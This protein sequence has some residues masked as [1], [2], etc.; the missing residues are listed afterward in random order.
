MST[1]GNLPNTPGATSTPE[2]NFTADASAMFEA[3]R[4]VHQPATMV[5]HRGDHESASFFVVPDR[6]KLH[7]VK[8]WLDARRPTPE[9][10]RGTA[11]LATLESFITHAKRS[12]GEAG[13]CAVFVDTTPA[14][15]SMR[16]IY[17]Y[18]Q[19]GAGSAGARWCDHGAL[20]RFPLSRA[21]RAWTSLGGKS[22][23]QAELAAFI[24][25][26]AHEVCPPE[27]EGAATAVL[28]LERVGLT[29]ATPAEVLTASRGLA[30]SVETVVENS[31]VL[32]TGEAAFIF[33]EKVR[34]QNGQ[35]LTVPGGFVIAV[36]VFEGA[37]EVHALPV[38][39]RFRAKDGVVT[40]TL[41]P[42]GADDVVRDAVLQAKERVVAE[43]P[44][45]EV[46]EGSPEA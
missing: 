8:G 42:L 35:K 38:R 30:A 31:T 18:H 7:D 1:Q 23:T 10:A 36:P 22:L 40:W 46:F 2:P 27:E 13:A 26:H 34:G 25:D 45:A 20:Y 19:P 41:L 9:R 17:N 12:M 16:S 14:S 29:V 44:G 33:S 5:A 24:E 32:Q 6:M 3:A 4:E 28:R 39:L 15:P 21:W 37:T 43:V 11:T